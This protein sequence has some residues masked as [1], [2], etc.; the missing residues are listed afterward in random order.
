MQI[1]VDSIDTMHPL[2][3]LEPKMMELN[4]LGFQYYEDGDYFK[5]DSVWTISLRINRK[6]YTDSDRGKQ[7]RWKLM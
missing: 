4:S 5:A 6:L 1:D 7:Y 2:D 3:S